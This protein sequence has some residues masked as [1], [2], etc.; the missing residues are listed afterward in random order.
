MRAPRT[1][2]MWRPNIQKHTIQFDGR[3]VQLNVCTR[4]LRT[5]QKVAK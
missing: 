5:A 3:S 1:K 4:C 2:R